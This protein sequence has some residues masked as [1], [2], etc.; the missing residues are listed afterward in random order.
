MGW[1]T[2]IILNVEDF[3]KQNIKSFKKKVNRFCQ[4]NILNF[5]DK[6]KTINS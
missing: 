1:N 6:K 5:Y 2:V 4:I 3:L